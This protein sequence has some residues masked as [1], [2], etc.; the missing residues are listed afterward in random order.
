V[1]PRSRGSCRVGTICT[2]AGRLARNTSQISDITL[3][4]QNVS[5]HP[6][7][8]L[9]PATDPP[10]R[11]KVCYYPTLRAAAGHSDPAAPPAEVL[12]VDL[13]LPRD[14]SPGAF[15]IHNHGTSMDNG[16]SPIHDC[17]LVVCATAADLPIEIL[18]D[19]VVL[20]QSPDPIELAQEVC[21]TSPPE[22]L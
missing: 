2:Q 18:L 22:S 8:V 7:R 17:D 5:E 10:T 9:S 13:D 16:K 21:S 3:R 15:A 6:S 20:A 14:P 1:W 11:H 12:K 19:R 4:R